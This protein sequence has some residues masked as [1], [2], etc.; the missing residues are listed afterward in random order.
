M[1]DRVIEWI[2]HLHEHFV[3]PAVVRNG[4]YVAPVE[5][6]N[7]MEMRADS[8]REYSYPDGPAWAALRS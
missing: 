5:A 4:R 3:S 7:S 1:D 2:D 8:I 6:G